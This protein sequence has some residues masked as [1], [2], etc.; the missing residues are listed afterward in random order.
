MTEKTYILGVG[1]QKAGTTWLAAELKK[2]NVRFPFGKEAHIWNNVEQSNFDQKNIA[3]LAIK[4]KTKQKRVLNSIKNPENYFK[5]CEQNF[6]NYGCPIADITPI[7]CS[8]DRP[9]LCRIRDGLKGMGFAIK[10]LFIARDPFS[11]VW[12]MQRMDIKR[13]L[14]R[15]PERVDLMLPEVAHKA[16]LRDFMSEPNKIR[17]AYE[18]I[19]P[20]LFDVFAAD[21]IGLFFYEDLF[22]MNTY[23]SICD[24]L[25]LAPAVPSFDVARNVSTV[26]EKPPTEIQREIVQGYRETYEYMSN[27]HPIVRHLWKNSFLLLD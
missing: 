11:R 14:K 27:E 6:L 21:E 3:L 22:S 10:V 24:F 4:S 2:L 20:K 26:I 8:L 13:R 25:R 15:N 23:Q 1:A 18:K 12:S 19:L 9:T 5:L 7:Y 17:T 16:L